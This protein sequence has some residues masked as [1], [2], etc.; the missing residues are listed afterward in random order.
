MEPDEA[1]ELGAEVKK[2]ERIAELERKVAAL[3]REMAN[4]PRWTWVN[5][6][7]PYTYPPLRVG[8]CTADADPI[9]RPT[10]TWGTTTTGGAQ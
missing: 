4:L 5:P 2:S 3:E 8:D 7:G 9:I 1:R 10:I 6:S